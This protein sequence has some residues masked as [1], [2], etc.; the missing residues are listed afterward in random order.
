MPDQDVT[1]IAD[2]PGEQADLPEPDPGDQETP[3]RPRIMIDI[4]GFAVIKIVAGLLALALLTNLLTQMRDVIVWT[5]AAAFLAIALNPLVVRLE[6]RIG[7]RPAATVVFCGFVIGFLA[8]VTAFVAPFVTQVDQL[9]TGLPTAISDA[10]HNS[11]LKRLDNKFHLANH[12]KQHLDALPNII[13]GAAGTVLGGAVA[14]S[15]VFFLTLFLLYELPALSEVALNQIS[16]KYRPRVVAAARHMNRNIGGYVAGNL[17]ISLI[18]GAV[19]TVSLYLL[20]VPYSLALGVFMAVFDLIP[21]VG[22]T[23]GSVVVIAAAFV[24]VDVRAGIIMFAIVMIY[25]QVENH[26][27]QPLIYGRTVQIPSLTVLI[28]VL[29][30]GAVLGLIGALLAIPI[31]G[32]IQAVAS[33]LLEERAERI[34]GPPEAGD[35]ATAEIEV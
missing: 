33:E 20:D 23:I 21:L 29:C 6:P 15:T 22:A 28:A 34:N 26:I 4:S 14:V 12:A 1:E 2:P 24:F 8:V 16:P 17:V 27:L 25:Q 10:R 13:F 35:V 11:T 7:R 32:T 5:L 30:G 19:T 31:A 18:C 3:R 9:S